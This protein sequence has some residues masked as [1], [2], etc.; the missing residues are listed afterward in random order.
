MSSAA[1]GLL[2]TV[3]FDNVSITN[4][5][6]DIWTFTAGT[7]S[8][9]IHAIRITFV[10]TITSGV[11]QDARAQLR[12]LIRSTAG[13]GGS[14]VTPRAQNPRNTVASLATVSRTTTTP[15]TA[16]N[17]MDSDQISIVLPYER[18]F[19]PAQRPFIPAA[20]IWSLNLENALGSAFNASSTIWF[21]E[22]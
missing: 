19:T 7:E 3:N 16:G 18:V 14:A 11:P 9:L 20:T 21:E 4:A 22:L 6:Q 17:V 2:Y 13:S 5:A 12:Q 8:I 10:P 15:G 1:N